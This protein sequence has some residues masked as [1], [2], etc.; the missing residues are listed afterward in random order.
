[1]RILAEKPRIPLVYILKLLLKKQ[2]I[3][4]KE[5]LTKFILI[6]LMTFFMG[7]VALPDNIKAKL[8]QEN[9][10]VQWLN[11]KNLKLGLDLQSGIQLDYKLD[12][13]QVNEYNR[14]DDDDNDV[15]VSDLVEGVK[16]TIERRVNSLGVSEPQIY[17]SDFGNEKHII[18]ELPGIED[19]EEAKKLIG[20]TIQLEFK[21]EKTELEKE[22]EDEIKLKANEALVALQESGTDLFAEQAENFVTA[23]NQ[24]IFNES[25]KLFEEE[26]SDSIKE[27][28][29]NA[30]VGEI[31][32]E[33]I[34][35]NEEIE[36]EGKMYPIKK[37]LSIIN[38]VAKTK[39]E[40]EVTEDG[41]DFLTV[42]NEVSENEEV[43]LT[44]SESELNE[45]QKEALYL[46]EGEI[47]SVIENGEFLETYKLIKKTEQKEMV[48][49]SHI[50]VAYEGADRADENITRTKE[51][52][53]L[54]ARQIYEEIKLAQTGTGA[55]TLT[56]S[57]LF[58][59]FAEKYSDG[60]SGKHGGQLGWFEKGQMT[61]AFEEVA[62]ALETGFMSEPIE[63]SF[64]YH[65]IRKTG[66]KQAEE[67]KYE[68]QRIQ[69]AKDA[70]GETQRQKIDAAH[71]RVIEQKVMREDDQI[72]YQELFFST[73]PTNWKATGLDGAHFKR[74]S[75]AFDQISGDALVSIEFDAEGG[76][77]FAEITERLSKQDNE[78]CRRKDKAGNI[79]SRGA[80]LAI[81][82]GGQM[83]STPCVSE[84]ISGGSAQITGNYDLKSASQLSQDLNTGAIPAPIN[85]DGQYKIGATLGDKALQTSLYAGLI[86]LLIL[87]L[88]MIL[89]YRLLGV[90]VNVALLI[91]T[92]IIVF[93][94]KSGFPIVMTLAGIAGI[95]L[96]IGMAV[97]ANI[98]IFERMKE[99]LRSGKNVS[100]AIKIG[101]ERAWSSIRDSNLSSLITCAIL[102]GFGTSIVKG[103]AVTL[104]IGIL[105]S[106]FT[107]ITVTR[108]IL[109]LI[110][111]TKLG[112]N[113]WLMGVG[114]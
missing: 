26:V 105:V 113:K 2:I 106:M 22:E 86:G 78:I 66:E 76:E 46:P 42:A 72:E 89:Y 87:G 21:E 64:G 102:F 5:L 17:T 39:A 112:K 35:F 25:V 56:G 90:V 12:L 75:V 14:D 65:I 79:I 27:K 70:I 93:I 88:Y 24:V 71:A 10:F 1:M 67:T 80:P 43:E 13:R 85:L 109:Y 51:E 101:F 57:S 74:A 98:L 94:L 69:V 110:L 97:D 55:D 47:T 99:E 104:S 40:H 52:A 18:V 44:I 114:K 91:Y 53:E 33:V 29:W 4:K 60:P 84:K 15:K 36:F 58:G 100:A 59:T 28:I 7:V 45:S 30:E 61:P 8:P 34:E 95:I 31:V 32:G 49:A 107:A 50:L 82:V 6:I 9:S 68:V 20:K 3:M 96:S 23:D 16:S 103:F 92:V 11:T 41:E 83:I 54:E 62:F 77:L 48:M 37:G 19:E 81:F 108:T 63:T 73:V 38:I 111:Q